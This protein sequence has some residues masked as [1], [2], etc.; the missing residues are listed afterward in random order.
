M[1]LSVWVLC[2]AGCPFDSYRNCTLNPETCLSCLYLMRTGA[3]VLCC[4][5]GFH[6]DPLETS[7]SSIASPSP[8]FLEFDLVHH[9]DEETV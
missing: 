3:W 2:G 6:T 7:F 5:L 4:G 1:Y 8:V 9:S